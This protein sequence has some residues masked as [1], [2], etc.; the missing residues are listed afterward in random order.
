MTWAI[1]LSLLGG[2]NRYARAPLIKKTALYRD[3][4]DLRPDPVRVVGQEI[5]EVDEQFGFAFDTGG[6][7]WVQIK[8]ILS[9]E[10]SEALRI[11]SRPSR[12]ARP[13]QSSV[14]QRL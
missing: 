9:V 11:V 1:S 5:P 8:G 3:R 10:A 2:A 4:L 14:R 6:N 12:K 13:R 7:T